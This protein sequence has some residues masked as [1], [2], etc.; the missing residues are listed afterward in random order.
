MA[1]ALARD[2]METAAAAG[3][4]VVVDLDI[5]LVGQIVLLLALLAILK[6]LLF[7]PMLKLFEEREKRIDGAKVQARRLD[8]A[9]AGALTKYETEMQRARA[10]GNLEREKLRSEGSKE[11]NEILGKVRESTT[12]AL[13]E[14]RS[15]L[16]AEAREVRRVLER[17]S[18][19]LGRELAGRV[20]GHEVE[21]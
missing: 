16:A 20:L 10:A 1:L 13:E 11:E 21:S 9:S 18:P 2:S 12:K 6:P 5:T 7:E 19:A 17:E 3:G 15:K 8:E 14:G 4:G